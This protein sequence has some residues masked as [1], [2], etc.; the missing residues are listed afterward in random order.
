MRVPSARRKKIVSEK[1]NLIPILDSVFILIFFLLFSVNFTNLFELH[2]E[3]PIISNSS[4]P[5]NKIP[6]LLTLKV[7]QNS[8]ELF[9]GL[10]LKNI[11]SFKNKN[12]NQR[13]ENLH[14]KIIEIK[15][16]NPKENDI[17]FEINL[18]I[19]YDKI[20][21]LMDIVSVLRPDDESIYYKDKSNSDIKV[22]NL[23]KN[24]IFNEL[25]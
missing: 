24:I 16:E 11:A 3:V 9:Q 6:F 13:N 25:N 4:P 20:V 14:K 19:S 17:V 5:Q 18:N 22:T 15:K 1:L 12:I 2:S 21:D 8:Y 7:N 23:F 10:E